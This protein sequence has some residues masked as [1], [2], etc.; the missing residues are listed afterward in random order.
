MENI[1]YY[2][3][4]LIMPLFIIISFVLSIILQMITVISLLRYIW[5]SLTVILVS[6]G[7]FF[8]TQ[9]LSKRKTHITRFGQDDFVQF[10]FVFLVVYLGLFFFDQVFKFS[11]GYFD[12]GTELINFSLGL[13][14]GVFYIL[15]LY[16]AMNHAL[17]GLVKKISGVKNMGDKKDDK[18]S[19]LIAISSVI[20]FLFILFV[21][22]KG[23]S[24]WTG[25]LH[26]EGN[27]LSVL[28]TGCVIGPPF[29]LYIDI[30][31]NDWR[32]YKKRSL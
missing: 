5:L 21:I 19:L 20:P 26:I 18:I 1:T 27:T 32:S 31:R 25:V 7:V 9:K 23:F 6:A 30:V 22:S 4:K 29:Y 3:N 15:I 10:S 11:G 16:L 2:K 8:I 17:F 14:S 13:L 28:M 24:Y 12:I